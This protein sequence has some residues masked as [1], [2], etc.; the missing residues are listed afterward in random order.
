MI[1][2]V[3]VVHVAMLAVGHA[4]SALFRLS[5]ADRIAVGFAGSQKTLMIGVNTALESFGGL[6]MFPM[7]AYH[8]CQLLIDALVAEWLVDRA[9]APANATAG[10]VASKASVPEQLDALAAVDEGEADAG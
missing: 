4:L 3:M 6:A 2:S 10:Q 7:V 1:A 9:A 5:R 8:V